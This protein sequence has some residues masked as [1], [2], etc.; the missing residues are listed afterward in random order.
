MDLEGKDT[1]PCKRL[2]RVQSCPAQLHTFENEQK[3]QKSR[4]AG[5]QPEEKQPNP[6]KMRRTCHSMS[7]IA[8]ADVNDPNGFPNATSRMY[9]VVAKRNGASVKFNFS[10]TDTIQ[11]MIDTMGKSTL[12]SSASC[13]SI[14]EDTLYHGGE[15]LYSQTQAGEFELSMPNG[16][17][18]SPSQPDAMTQL[19]N[20]INNTAVSLTE[21]SL[22]GFMSPS[23][24]IVEPMGTHTGITSSVAFLHK[25]F[26]EKDRPYVVIK[27]DSSPVPLAAYQE[28]RSGTLMADV[29]FSPVTVECKIRW[30]TQHAVLSHIQFLQNPRE[31]S[32]YDNVQNAPTIGAG[33]GSLDDL[34]NFGSDLDLGDVDAAELWAA[35]SKALDQENASTI[36][37]NASLPSWAT[38]Q[39]SLNQLTAMGSMAEQSTSGLTPMLTGLCTTQPLAAAVQLQPMQPLPPVSAQPGS[40]LVLTAQMETFGGLEDILGGELSELIQEDPALFQRA[41]Q[42]TKPQ[43][44]APAKAPA[45]ARSAAKTAVKTEVKPAVHELQLQPVLHREG[46]MRSK[47]HEA[48]GV[49][50]D[51]VCGYCGHS[52][53]SASAC[54]DGRVR[55]RCACGG[56]H[57]DGKPRMHANWRPLNGVVVKPQE[58][59]EAIEA[60]AIEAPAEVV[61]KSDTLSANTTAS[62]AESLNLGGP[63]SGLSIKAET[64]VETETMQIGN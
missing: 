29:S 53:T 9:C 8:A 51:Y 42:Q 58:A 56:K 34:W 25:I 60:P 1:R 33:G 62:A 46:Y 41:A 23:I 50:Q 28:M 20:A 12:R 52:R 36:V 14:G 37:R 19:T 43:L 31:I 2:P 39:S 49:E 18:S 17:A 22:G 5:W 10:P 38:E 35:T 13:Q 3:A 44:K 4:P 63:M 24:Q 45:K 48:R 61:D 16:S 7:N 15:V 27:E 11:S 64:M 32:G 55:I 21:E 57:K 40:E 59:I 30:S 54:S 47:A 26:Q 6:A